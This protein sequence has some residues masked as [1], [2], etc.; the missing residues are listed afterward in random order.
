MALDDMADEVVLVQT[1]DESVIVLNPDEA[2]ALVDAMAL[3]EMANQGDFQGTPVDQSLETPPS[4]PQQ[5]VDEFLEAPNAPQ[6]NESSDVLSDV[7]VE[8]AGS[9]SEQVGNETRLGENKKSEDDEISRLF[10]NL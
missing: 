8:D 3:D 4:A 1:D 5:S 6:Q 7:W 2:A 10:P 9:S